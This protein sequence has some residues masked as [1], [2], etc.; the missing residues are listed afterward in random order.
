MRER[1]KIVV[2]ATAVFLGGVFPFA[3]AQNGKEALERYDQ[4]YNKDKFNALA[5]DD[6]LITGD[7]WVNNRTKREAAEFGDFRWDKAIKFDADGDGALDIHE[8]AA[9]KQAEKQALINHRKE[10]PALYENQDWLKNHP[11]IAKKI[12]SNNEWLEKHPKVASSIYKNREWLN[13]HPEVAKEAYKDRK[14]L[15]NHPELS[16]DL[17]KHKEYLNNH[18]KAVR[19]TYNKAREHSRA[20][21]KVYNTGKNHPR[22]AKRAIR[23]PKKTKRVYQRRR[24]R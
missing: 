19:K 23:H 13:N 18:P 11:A 17:Y 8:A 14:F 7:D 16:K 15:N 4:Y 22:A 12:V 24:S 1:A 20:A 2:L 10:L 9:Y 6:G 5:G 21:K 3:F